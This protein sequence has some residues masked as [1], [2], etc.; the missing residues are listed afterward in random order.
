LRRRSMQ[1]PS[2]KSARPIWRRLFGGPYHEAKPNER[3]SAVPNDLSHDRSQRASV[4]RKF[5]RAA[6]HV[7]QVNGKL[8]AFEYGF[9]SREG[10]KDREWYKHLGTAPGKNLGYGATTLPALT[11]AITLDKNATLAKLEISRLEH[12]LANMAERL[13]A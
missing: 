12:L 2:C 13:F 3:L 5:L 1:K 6:K 11:E 7:Q 9:I 10:I 4:P 8:S